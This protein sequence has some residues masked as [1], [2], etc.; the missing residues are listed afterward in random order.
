M[1]LN[2]LSLSELKK[3]HSDVTKAIDGYEDRK[4]K[5]ARAVLEEKAKEMGFSLAELLGTIA[6]EAR[7]RRTA[8]VKYRNPKD[9][10]LTWTGRGRKPKWVAEALAAGKSLSDLAI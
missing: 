2:N 6:P 9:S 1:D 4:K 5:E 10:K 3:L 7:K 8:A